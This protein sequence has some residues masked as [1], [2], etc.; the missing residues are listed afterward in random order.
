MVTNVTSLTRNG[1]RDWLVQRVSAIIVGTYSIF[2]LAFVLLNPRM[3]YITWGQLF[4]NPWM[5]MFSFLERF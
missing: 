4:G 1:L 3:D 5:R 2:L